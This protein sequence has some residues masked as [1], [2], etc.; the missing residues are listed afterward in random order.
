[1]PSEPLAS[2]VAYV[3]DPSRWPPLTHLGFA[4]FWAWIFITLADPFILDPTRT[5]EEV[6]LFAAVFLG[7]AAVLRAVAAVLAPYVEAA[8]GSAP[9]LVAGALLCAAGSI[10]ASSARFSMGPSTALLVVGSVLCGIG[11]AWQVLA[12]GSVYADIG[13]WRATSGAAVCVG[14][15]ALVYLLVSVGLRP[16]A[17]ISTAALLPLIS[18]A[19]V[20]LSR[21]G[22]DLTATETAVKS[23]R[24]R[25]PWRFVLMIAVFGVAY[26][27]IYG[28]SNPNALDWR[29]AIGFCGIGACLLLAWL[30]FAT[31]ADNAVG[32]IYR[33]LLPLLSAAFLLLPFLSD[34]FALANAIALT[35]CV[36]FGI[37]LWGALSAV[38]TR[39]PISPVK[40]FGWGWSAGLGILVGALGGRLL[41]TIAG[42]D[43]RVLSAV[44]LGTAFMLLVATLLLLKGTD[45]LGE[46]A[47]A[48][49]P[50]RMAPLEYSEAATSLLTGR[51]ALSAREKEVLA[52]LLRGRSL[53]YIAEECDIT[54]N[55]TKSHVRNV[56][57]KT[58]VHT[59]QQLLDLAQ[60]EYENERRARS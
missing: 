15:G 55:T 35:A 37:T 36:G 3:R 7:T 6:H 43:Y 54:L 59:R 47:G 48:Q 56:Y 32:V 16:L 52:L 41:T 33:I 45:V 60:A 12:W 29:L 51:Y 30:V 18:G 44:S 13:Y 57:N 24:L 58:G 14:L 34:P 40:V 19:G 42:S 1:M 31:L 4:A 38:T 10:A 23:A 11:A 2:R 9:T 50:V 21:R 53:P 22:R 28:I 39:M 20:L 27:L 25:L 26:G 5:S 17:T 46:P 8:I 49:E